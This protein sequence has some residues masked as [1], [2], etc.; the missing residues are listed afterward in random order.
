MTDDLPADPAH[1]PGLSPGQDELHALAA[2]RRL[3]V[4]DH[5]FT[6]PGLPGTLR[7]QLFTAAGARPIAVAT[8]IAGEEGKT[9]MNGAETYAGAVWERHCPDQD[10]PP[11]WVERQLW[12]Q[13]PVQETRFR[14][15]VFA[16]ADRYRPHGPH[17][18]AITHEQLQDLVGAPVATDRG[19]G[20]VPRPAEVEPRLVFEEFA[21]ARLA[22]PR[23]FREPQCMPAG[24]PWWRRWTRQVLPRRSARS[25][26]WYHGGDWHT[27]NAM[28]L[29]V[30]REAHAQDV[31]PEGMEGFATAHA[32]AAGATRWQTEALATL[33]NTANAIQPDKEVRYING[34]HRSQAML[35]AGVRRTVVLHHVYET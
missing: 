6:A 3:S 14:R 2:R 20:Y 5:M 28:G 32:A 9:L 30:L 12:P 27:V 15:V 8:Q 35:E 17:W 21:V 1:E 16:G 33:F 13:E 31:D 4:D 22:R 26:C 34:Q 24:V 7:L 18:S 19:T 25:C 10:L 11:V 29:E 23:P